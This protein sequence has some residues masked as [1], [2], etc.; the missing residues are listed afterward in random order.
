MSPVQG[1]SPLVHVKKPYGYLA[2]LTC[3]LSSC[4]QSI[5]KTPADY[6][7]KRVWQTGSEGRKDCP[8]NCDDKNKDF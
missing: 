8:L 4:N 2:M 3:R 7:R 6:T 1:K 5:Q